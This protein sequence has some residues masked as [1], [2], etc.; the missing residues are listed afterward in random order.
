LSAL[1]SAAAEDED[2]EVRW[3]A[4]YALRLADRG[5]SAGRLPVPVTGCSSCR[6]YMGMR[7]GVVAG[8]AAAGSRAV[9]DWDSRRENPRARREI[10]GPV[11]DAKPDGTAL[12]RRHT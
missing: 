1:P 7:G 11:A 8:Q 3:A 2:V 9:H 10:A 5:I 6:G 4:L 12:I